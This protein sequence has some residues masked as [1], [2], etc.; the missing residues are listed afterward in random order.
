MQKVSDLYKTASEY[1]LVM[2]IIRTN[3]GTGKHEATHR[4]VAVKF[5]DRYRVESPDS[6]GQDGKTLK[7]LIVV[8]D[9]AILWF[10]DPNLNRYKSY[11]ATAI[12][13]DLPDELE[14]S[15]IDY[16]TMS[17]FREASKNAV[18][19][20]FRRAEE[21]AIR[22]VKVRCYVVSLRQRNREYTWWIDRTNSHV[23]REDTQEDGDNISTTFTTIK[24]RGP[25]PEGLF[26]FAPPPGAL[27]GTPDPR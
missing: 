27:K 3:S 9:G 20:S 18:A 24:L 16:G 6:T 22:G 14:V 7:G 25:I 5:P 1:E 21:I 13:T 17:R 8:F 23:V 12:G 15:G 26:A 19:A 4:L 2:D 10:Y 11:P